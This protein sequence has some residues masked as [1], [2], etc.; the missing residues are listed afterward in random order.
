MSFVRDANTAVRI[1][2]K[3][4][5]ASEMAQRQDGTQGTM[6][7]DLDG[8]FAA[9]HQLSAN[10]M[11]ILHRLLPFYRDLPPDDRVFDIIAQQ[12]VVSLR[13]IDWL[14]TNYAKKLNICLPCAGGVFNIHVGYKTALQQYRRR[15]FDPFRR[16]LRLFVRAGERML[17][18]TVGQLNFMHW[19][20]TT[21]VLD[22]MLTGEHLA[23]LEED[24]NEV[25]VKNRKRKTEEGSSS[26]RKR[27]E[28]SKAPATKCNV[29]SMG[30]TIHWFDRAAE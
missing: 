6:Q 29:F 5:T 4:N 1:V 21:G 25:S 30:T 20:T 12:S 19:L 24:M 7:F 18:T 28:L 17:E 13:A 11:Q 16:R 8:V 27:N 26:E 22:F 23:R 15:N 2:V 10:Q 3:T 9:H 14:V